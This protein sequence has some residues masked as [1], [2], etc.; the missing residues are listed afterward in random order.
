MASSASIFS[1]PLPQSLMAL[2]GGGKYLPEA[3]IGEKRPDITTVEELFDRNKGE[4]GEWSDLS[5]RRHPRLKCRAVFMSDFHL[6]T[7]SSC[8]K[9][10]N[11]FLSHIEPEY[12]Y[13]VGDIVDCWRMGGLDLFKIHQQGIAHTGVL[14]KLIKM[15]RHGVKLVYIPG[16]H[17]EWFRDRLDKGLPSHG[18]TILFEATHETKDGRRILIMH[19]DSFDEIVRANRW[20]AVLGTTLYEK[21][22]V[23]STKIDKWRAYGGMNHLFKTLGFHETWSLAH[24]LRQASDKATY[25]ESY[26]RAALG[27]L[28]AKN[29][30]IL[31][32]N[33][34]HPN[35]NP[36]P[37]YDE[38]M[39][40]HTHIPMRKHMAYSPLKNDPSGFHM[41]VTLSNTGCWVG[42]PY[43]DQKED[44]TVQQPLQDKT[45]SCTAIIEDKNGF[46]Q[47]VQWVPKVGIVP[48]EIQEDGFLHAPPVQ[49]AIE[50]NSSFLSQALSQENM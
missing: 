50:R 31:V 26:E 48:L 11:Q 14:Q 40:A 41:R 38:I 17:D 36:L 34:A 16:N 23:L 22:A 19:G 44:Q 5:L 24:T 18:L 45:P 13:L 43:S 4:D 35:E 30:E 37:L 32:W 39:C 49:E 9:S 10:I 27:Y 29:A 7:S 15:E 25:N 42:E 3:L 20:L 12:L 2:I 47:H 46:L 1:A 21:L 6:G 8:A 33:E 28:F